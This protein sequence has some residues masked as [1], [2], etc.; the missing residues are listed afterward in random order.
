ML[1]QFIKLISSNLKTSDIID[2]EVSFFKGSKTLKEFQSEFYPKSNNTL[3]NK[4]EIFTLQDI[5]LKFT[6]TEKNINTFIGK[7][8]TF[9]TPYII[10]LF[11][12]NDGWISYNYKHQKILV[13]FNGDN[14]ELYPII[15]MSDEELCLLFPLLKEHIDFLKVYKSI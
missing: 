13:L 5:T 2:V 7:V 10:D 12:K 6:H 3:F 4:E 15:G 1:E 14:I 9:Q 8:N 11:V